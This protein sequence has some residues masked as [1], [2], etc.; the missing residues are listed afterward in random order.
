MLMKLGN[1]R[2]FNDY[3]LIST[4]HNE[5]PKFHTQYNYSKVWFLISSYS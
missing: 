5:S 2:N 4:V 1:L 3:L